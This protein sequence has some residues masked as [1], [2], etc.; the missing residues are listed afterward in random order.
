MKVILNQD[1]GNLGE[2]GDVLDVSDGY[3][4]NYLLP[5][6]LVLQHTKSNLAMIEG[7]RARIEQKK[8]AKR[9][10]AETLKERL[11]GESLTISMMAGENGKLFG[12]VTSAT[13]CDE[14]AKAGIDVERKRIDVPDHSL[15]TVGNFKVRVRLYGENEATLTVSVVP[16]GEAAPA[17]PAEKPAEKRDETPDESDATE[18]PAE[19]VAESAGDDATVPAVEDGAVQE[20]VASEADDVVEESVA[21]DEETEE[22]VDA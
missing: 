2:E 7:R 12:S 15:K 10:N 9:E 19:S 20:S 1:V 21:V 8:A 4:R 13:I 6:G 18:M 17:A 14:L 5:N 16:S 3:A 22:G 11:E